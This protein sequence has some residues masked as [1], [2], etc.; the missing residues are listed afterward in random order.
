MSPGQAKKADAVSEFITQ[1]EMETQFTGDNAVSSDDL[2]AL[3][4][5]KTE[6]TLKSRVSKTDKLMQATVAETRPDGNVENSRVVTV[7]GTDEIVYGGVRYV[8]QRD[9]NNAI[10]KSR[11][12]LPKGQQ[13]T[14]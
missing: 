9:K 4:E 2:M 14:T 11:A 5:I 10:R 13:T 12:W 8:P 1:F 7:K 6:A 3:L